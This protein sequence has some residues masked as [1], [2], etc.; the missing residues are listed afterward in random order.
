[1]DVFLKIMTATVVIEAVI[2]YL[3]CAHRKEFG[4]KCWLSIGLGIAFAL[5]YRIDLLYVLG[6][7][8]AVPKVGMV[9]SGILLSRGSN[10]M[11][12]LIKK[13]EG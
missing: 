6:L 4:S 3:G 12:D 7:E 2:E 1:M 8:A 13:L 5:A 10:Y 9:L 11:A